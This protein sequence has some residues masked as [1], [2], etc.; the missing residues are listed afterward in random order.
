MKR[1]DDIIIKPASS[2]REAM[3][4]MTN[5]RKGVV[6]IVNENKQLL[7]ILSDGDVRRGI[8]NET[9]LSG[10]VSHIMNTDPIVAYSEA[11]AV[12]LLNMHSLVLVPVLT[13]ELKIISVIVVDG[14][15]PK[16]FQINEGEADQ[17]DDRKILVIIP[18]RGGSKRIPHKN[19]QKI[20]GYSLLAR[21]VM[22][23]REAFNKAYILVSTDDPQIVKEAER[24][25]ITVPWLRPEHL[26]TDSSGTYEVVE[27]ALLW[28]LEN[29]NKDLEAVV[30]LEPTAPLRQAQHLVEAVDILRN[31]SYD[32][33]VS[34]CE[35]PHV[36]HPEEILKVSD[37]GL[38]TPYKS[39]RK[40][41]N[42]LLRGRQEKVFMQ[43]G[44]VYVTKPQT[45]LSS[46]N[47]YGD[48]SAPYVTEWKYFADIDEPVD[49]IT[50]ESKLKAIV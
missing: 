13:K 38:L 50:A 44:N 43:N 35:V 31:G 28:A 37:K 46:K 32:S 48:K 14:G 36:F 15:V 1:I 9:L 41:E 34:V 33:V 21:A 45:I 42:R 16:S 39:E 19:L 18:A 12:E 10:P 23:A 40:M 22:T 20:G 8:L 29:L 2:I 30:L 3:E 6:L 27:H 26:S 7:G 25:G 17:Y 24:M 47:L 5:S 4:Q 49:L 11:E